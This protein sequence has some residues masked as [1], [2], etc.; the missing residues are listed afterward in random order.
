MPAPLVLGEGTWFIE[1]LS[2]LTVSSHRRRGPLPCLFSPFFFS[3]SPPS[4]AF[5]RAAPAAYGRSQARD[6]RH[7]C[8][9]CHIWWQRHILN[10]LSDRDQTCI[11]METNQVLRLLSRNEN[12]FFSSSS[13]SFFFLFSFF[14]GLPLQQMEVPRLVVEL[15]LQLRAAP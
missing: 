14:S 5:F 7:I 11:L 15:E 13:S 12:Y 8:N 6:P 1:G 10:P 4:P 9:V 2:V 3:Y